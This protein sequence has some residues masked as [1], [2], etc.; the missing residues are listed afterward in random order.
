MNVIELPKDE[1]GNFHG[2]FV[3]GKGGRLF[4]FYQEKYQCR[5]DIF[6]DFDQKAENQDKN[7]C[8]G[9]DNG[10]DAAHIAGTRKSLCDPY[11]LVTSKEGKQ[12][13]DNCLQFI[14]HRIRDHQERWGV[15]RDREI[16]QVG[17]KRRMK[18]SAGERGRSSGS[19]K[20]EE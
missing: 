16:E 12:N 6:G 5:V 3:A 19:Q 14:E 13:V 20:N 15:S 4:E 18:R 7:A 2:M 11:V 9:D 17:L 1:E 10:D 8:E